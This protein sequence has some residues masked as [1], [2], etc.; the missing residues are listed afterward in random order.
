MAQENITQEPAQECTKVTTEEK[1]LAETT[2]P[3]ADTTPKLPE[4]D[5]DDDDVNSYYSDR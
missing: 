4:R 1:D 5:D 3:L 2:L